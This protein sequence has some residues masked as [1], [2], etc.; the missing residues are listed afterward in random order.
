MTKNTPQTM[1]HVVEDVVVFTRPD[2]QAKATGERSEQ[3][4]ETELS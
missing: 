1:M 2:L 3:V 4:A